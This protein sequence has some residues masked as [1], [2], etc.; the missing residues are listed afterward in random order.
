M[1]APTLFPIIRRRRVPLT[2]SANPVRSE[3]KPTDLN[4][5]AVTESTDLSLVGQVQ[6]ELPQSEVKSDA[7]H[8]NSVPPDFVPTGTGHRKKGRQ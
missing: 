2:V 7:T 1:I 4:R 3:A 5:E 6:S 8:S